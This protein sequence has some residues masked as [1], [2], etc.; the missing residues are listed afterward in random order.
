MAPN[1]RKIISL[2]L[3]LLLTSCA[4]YDKQFQQDEGTVSVMAYNMENLFDTKHDP[5]TEDHSYLPVEAKQTEAHKSICREINHGKY[6]AE[7]FDM[8]WSQTILVRKMKRL[9]D[10][11]L[12][13]NQGR[14][15]DI[16]IVEEVENIDV[17]NELN[18][19]YLQPANYQT[20]RLIEG[21]DK[22]GIDIGLLSRLPEFKKPILHKI[23]YKGKTSEDQT[24]MDRSRG[25][26]QAFLVLPDKTHLNV[27]GIH[28]PSGSNPTYW[29]QQSISYL[30]QLMSQIPKGEL[31]I[32]GGDFNINSQE[33]ATYKLYKKEIGDKW[34]VSH[35]IG[36][37]DCRGT[38][39]YHRKRQWS[40]L[41]ALLFHK[42]LD[43]VNGRSGWFV[44]PHSVGIP[45]NSI[46]QKNRFM[47]PARFEAQ[48]PVGVSDHWP[49]FAVLKLRSSQAQKQ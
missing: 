14:G 38:N 37:K 45:N 43:P 40:F 26:L 29:R 32:A 35:Q 24:W 25:I 4:T 15:P 3:L 39:Y 12:Q 36:C 19:N 2:F 8:D 11:I 10:V 1:M 9:A 28:F 30:N 23:P 33:D 31:A 42:D 44:E 34:L 48:S 46:Y 13:V 18:K 47:S 20:V 21:F 5:G 17:L 7:C 27:F 22:R 41:D 49:I 6:R 16:L